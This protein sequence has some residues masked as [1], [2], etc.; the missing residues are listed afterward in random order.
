MN[1]IKSKEWVPFRT[2]RDF[3][4]YRLV[5]DSKAE[6]VHLKGHNP[7]VIEVK[8]SY[9]WSVNSQPTWKVFKKYVFEDRRKAIEY[10]INILNDMDIVK[11]EDH[12]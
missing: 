2:D 6:R 5:G 7:Y 8:H 3:D 10:Y 12:L 1:R 4:K 11:M 9:N